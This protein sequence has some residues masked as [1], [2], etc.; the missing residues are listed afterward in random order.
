MDIPVD[1]GPISLSY[2]SSRDDLLDIPN[3]GFTGDSLHSPQYIDKEFSNYSYSIMSIDPSGRG[4]DEMGYSVIKYLHGRI[5]VMACGGMQGG[6]QMDNLVRLAT[7][8]K[9]LKKIHPVSIEEVRS[10]KQK[11]L[12][13][14]DTIEPLLNQHKLVFD[15]RMVSQDIKESLT[16]PQKL[17]YGLM[18]QLTHI[19]RT[20]GCLGHDDRLDA[21]AIALAAIVET[22]GM[23]EDEA[24]KE[25]KD[26][27]LQDKLDAFVG[28]IQNPRWTSVASLGTQ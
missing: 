5:F 2:S 11:E 24:Y 17:A 20:R 3:I 22:V 27:Q 13:I 21:L 18:Y 15:K 7:I 4:S 19:T 28:N 16:D 25:F 8:A 9:E 23:D 12:R 1:R 10:S 14:I 26:Q 6:Y